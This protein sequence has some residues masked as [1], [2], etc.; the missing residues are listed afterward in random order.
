MGY[1]IYYEG[2][3]NIDKPLDEETC[4]II[5]GLGETRRMIWDTDKLE[6]DGIARK[7]DIG[8][9]GEFFFGF[10]D[11]KPK[12][13]RELEERYVI[14]HNCPPPGQPALWGVWTV[15][16]DRE[17]LV[18]NRN[19]KSYCGHE[20]LQYLVKRVLAPRGYCTS[21]IVNW[22]TEDSWNGNKWHTIVDGTSVRKH[23]GYSKQQ[24]EPDIDAWYQEEIES[25][26][27]YHQNWLKNLMENGTEFLHERKPSSSDDT[28][29]E[30]VLSF[31]VC[32]D[33][34]IIQV[35]FDRSRIYSAKYL[36]KNLRRDGDQ[37]THDE[38]TDSEAQI[39]DPDVPMRTQAVIERYMSMHP[40]F[41]QDAFW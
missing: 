33:D 16:E 8:Y 30:T 13:Q 9:F 12:K 37:I 21:G 36:Y 14:D 10:P 1:N 26:H 39:E 41:L 35:T 20:W 18:W 24:K 11:V 15:T 40:D 27:Q 7:E 31:N 17:A 4:R 3:V 22:F 29:A 19:E 28:D 6:Q 32:V 34:D 23:R 38:R 5:R 2:T 25:Y